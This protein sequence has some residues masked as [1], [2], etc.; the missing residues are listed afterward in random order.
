M[1]IYGHL[2]FG[3]CATNSGKWGILEKIFTN[4]AQQ[5]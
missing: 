5:R 3:P 1:A 4:V 2:V